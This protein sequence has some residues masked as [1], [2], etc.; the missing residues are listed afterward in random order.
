MSTGPAVAD[1][2][3]QPR[4]P[5]T[6][7]RVTGLS[8]T[9][10]GTKALDA[11]SDRKL[12]RRRPLAE[13]TRVQRTVVAIAAALVGWEGGPGVLVL[14]EPTAVLPPHDVTRL[15][16]IINRVRSRGTSILYVSHRLDE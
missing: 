6:V 5:G 7:L 1:I 10:P 8:K 3:A 9:F 11:N 2:V 4:A 13:A 15:L 14:D 16:E 12:D